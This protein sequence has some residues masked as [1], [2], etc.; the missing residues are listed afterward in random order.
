MFRAWVDF[1]IPVPRL[2]TSGEETGAE[3]GGYYIKSSSTGEELP[4]DLQGRRFPHFQVETSPE[5]VV[6]SW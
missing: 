3:N 1:G 2:K 4:W 5:A 6:K